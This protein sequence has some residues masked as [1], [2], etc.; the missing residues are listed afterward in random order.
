MSDSLSKS[1]FENGGLIAWVVFLV[2]GFLAW[3]TCQARRPQGEQKVADAV[4]SVA[5]FGVVVT[6]LWY[7]KAW[8]AFPSTWPDALL[9]LGQVIVTPVILGWVFERIVSFAA[10]KRW[11][12]SPHPRAWD[13]LFNDFA[14]DKDAFKDSGMFLV[15]T[16]RDGQ[17]VA[18]LYTVPGYA[19]LWPYDRDLFLGEM[20]EMDRGK[21]KPLRKVAGSIGLYV[22]KADIL[23]IE[24]LD[25]RAVVSAAVREGTTQ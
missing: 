4:G 21:Q 20:W 13:Y 15:L 23:T 17:K 25:Y 19:S 9:F 18:G 22:D 12:T 10:D 1:F 7:W 3:R 24:V 11:I 6:V 2:P 14:Y 5:A 16:L 8:T